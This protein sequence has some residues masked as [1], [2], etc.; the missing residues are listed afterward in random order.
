MYAGVRQQRD[1]ARSQ[2][3]EID[4]CKN[5]Q[6]PCKWSLKLIHERDTAIAE[7]NTAI[8]QRDRLAVALEKFTNCFDHH[9]CSGTAEEAL[10]ARERWYVRPELLKLFPWCNAKEMSSADKENQPK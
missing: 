10:V 4:L 6:A 2:F 1:E 8:E 3:N 5:G 9:E 7:L